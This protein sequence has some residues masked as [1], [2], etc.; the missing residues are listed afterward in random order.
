MNDLDVER[1][2]TAAEVAPERGQR[3]NRVGV[4]PVGCQVRVDGVEP[5]ADVFPEGKADV[6]G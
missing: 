4:V 1:D 2:T 6:T 3:G 5:A